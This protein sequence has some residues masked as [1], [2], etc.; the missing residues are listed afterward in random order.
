VTFTWTMTAS[1]GDAAC[2]R[3]G[4]IA[5]STEP[6]CALDCTASVPGSANTGEIIPFAGE[7]TPS[8][9]AGPVAFFWDFGDGSTSD[10]TD[11]E[12]AY[13]VAGDYAWTFRSTADDAACTRSGA[14]AVSA[15]NPPSVSGHTFLTGPFRLKLSG[16]G[17]REG[18]QVFLDADAAPWPGVERKSEAKLLLGKGSALKARF[19]KGTAV[20]VRLRN[21]DGG[22]VVTAVTR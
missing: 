22:E 11:P 5:A 7:A 1:S 21:P 20:P 4:V 18:I 3:T 10:R 15:A 12:H 2:V 19:P 16:A 9:C 6:W 13:A 8:G 14:I 17:F